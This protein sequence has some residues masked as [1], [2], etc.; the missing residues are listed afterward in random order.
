MKQT[1]Q[2]LFI[3]VASSNGLEFPLQYIGNSVS[4]EEANARDLC[5]NKYCAEDSE[6]L[7]YAETQNTSVDPCVNFREFTL[8]TFL[9]F[10]AV[11]DRYGESELFF[12]LKSLE[13]EK[14]RKM[15]S[16]N[17]KEK[18]MTREWLK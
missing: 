14:L 5:R 3:F 13:L 12:H 10:R 9:K 11:N 8:G 2:F 18:K 7:F 4:V 15:L 1:F 6:I 17:I 16:S